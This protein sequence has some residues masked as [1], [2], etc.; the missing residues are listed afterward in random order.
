[1]MYKSKP[2]EMEA[3]RYTGDNYPEIKEFVG[4]DDI[5]RWDGTVTV[6]TNNGRVELKLG[7][8]ICKGKSDFYPCD[9]ETFH[10]RWEVVQQSD[11]N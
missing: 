11:D 2:I 5:F 8:F 1:M 10:S 7:H 3:I 9:P 4:S 6:T